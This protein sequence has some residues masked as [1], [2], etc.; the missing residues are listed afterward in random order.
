MCHGVLL[1]AERRLRGP[2]SMQPQTL[3]R[4]SVH[5]TSTQTPQP[6]FG[7]AVARTLLLDTPAMPWKGHCGQQ[8]DSNEST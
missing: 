2:Q 8:Q 7:R 3:K 4:S 6:L 5:V 1:H